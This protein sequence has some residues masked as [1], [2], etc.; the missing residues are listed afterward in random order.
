VS[1]PRT[2]S[3]VPLE[4][5]NSSTT[6]RSVWVGAKG[7]IYFVDGVVHHVGNRRHRCGNNFEEVLGADVRDV[8]D[9]VT[10]GLVGV[11]GG[12]ENVHLEK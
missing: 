4:T 3:V 7:L 10:A 12:D 6:K 8:F 9:Q 5:D 11:V 2:G 1:K